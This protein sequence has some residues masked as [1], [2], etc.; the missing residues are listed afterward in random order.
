MKIEKEKEKGLG[1]NWARLGLLLVQEKAEHGR[2]AR[3]VGNRTGLLA[4]WASLGGYEL[5]VWPT[6]LD[7][8]QR[9]GGGKGVLC[10]YSTQGPKE[11]CGA[12]R[13]ASSCGGVLARPRAKAE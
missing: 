11:Q 4:G 12:A 1:S 9:K 10:T 2:P 6:L 13:Q 7:Q 8:K 3:W 5:L